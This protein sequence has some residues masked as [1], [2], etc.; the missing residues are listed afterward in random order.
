MK[1]VTTIPAYNEQDALAGVIAEIPRQIAGIEVVQV[2]VVDD[3]SSDS[4]VE[5]AKKAGA[6]KVLSHERNEG[7][8]VAFR[9]GLEAALEMGA[10]IIVNIDADG[11]YDA[12]EIPKL[13]GPILDN[14]ADVVLG[15]R[16]VDTL[17]FMPRG[18]KIG[19]RVATWFTRTL[20]GLPIKDAQTGFRAFSKEAALRLELAAT[21]T[22]VQETLIQAKYHGLRIAQ[23]PVNFREREGESRLIRSVYSYALRAGPAM[24]SAYWHYHLQPFILGLFAPRLKKR[25]LHREEAAYVLRRQKTGTGR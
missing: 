17:G 16:D 21:Y 12:T 14:K 15:W 6:D 4:T 3:G 7:L 8:G 5:I 18:K 22:Y 2:L 23:V 13:I 24:F 10:D 25:R 1:L 20:S 11:Q 9:D 19:N